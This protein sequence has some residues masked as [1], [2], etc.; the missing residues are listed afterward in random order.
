M[1]LAS[2]PAPNYVHKSRLA[3]SDLNIEAWE[4]V[5]H[6]IEPLDP[7]LVDQ[8]KYGFDMSIQRDAFV[9]V[10]YTNHKSAH[11][12]HSVVDDFVYKHWLSGAISGP[13]DYN[14]LPV[15]VHPSPLQVATS[16]AGKKCPVIDMS[17]PKGT[18]I[19]DAIVKDW[20]KMPGYHGKFRLPTHD[21]MC[22]RVLELNDPVMSITD[23]KA[24]YMQ[25][26]S[27]LNDAPYLAFIWRSKLYIHRRLPFGCRSS[28]LAAQRVT[29]AVCVIHQSETVNSH[30]SGYVDDFGQINE[31]WMSG[32]AHAAFH[33]LLHRL[34]LDRSEDKDQ[35]PGKIRIFLG[36]LYNLLTCYLQL[37]EE[38]L[39]RVINLIDEWLQLERATKHQ[40]E[41]L[42]G[43]L[44]H[45]AAVV[46]AGRP[47]SAAI[48]D[49][50]QS[51][52]F[53]VEVDSEL[54]KDLMMWRSFLTRE[55]TCMSTMK[56]SLDLPVDF[57]LAVAVKRD[58]CVIRCNE[59]NHGYKVVAEWYIPPPI[60]FV[61]ALWIVTTFHPSVIQ[62]KV[63][64]VSV[65]TK[66]ASK[67][68]NRGST[69]CVS[70]RGLIRDL[71]LRQA[72]L[73][74]HVRAQLGTSNTSWLFSEFLKFET[75]HL[76]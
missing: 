31:L 45:V 34:G 62:N 27:D 48:Y 6:I 57:E 14:P 64:L 41:A 65:P 75:V 40:L 51:G 59:V 22:R 50:V 7:T 1:L 32:P 69:S 37:P 30:V 74:A 13:Y 42:A 53:P 36:L 76:P 21:Q 20:D 11:V 29:D 44:N 72:L 19:N 2:A 8:I 67:V 17:Y 43:L 56:L 15:N 38:K 55:S 18:S 39:V 9:S 35:L 3:D 63:T 73:D 26:P 4:A 52:E 23:L 49:L 70:S 47:F 10:P 68:I 60:M 12:D 66:V 58:M 5:S 25:L 24:Y 16:S 28:C 46:H 61:A 33:R 71:W 54:K